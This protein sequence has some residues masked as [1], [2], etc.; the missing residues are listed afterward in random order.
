MRK[1]G[2]ILQA[3][4]TPPHY[5]EALLREMRDQLVLAE[6]TYS[7]EPCNGRG[8]ISRLLPAYVLTNDINP[9]MKADFH[10]DATRQQ[11]WRRMTRERGKPFWTITNPPFKH[12]I[13]ILRCALAYSHNVAML[14]RLSFLEPTKD[15]VEL[16]QD[17]PPDR[18][19][20]LPRYRFKG[21]GTDSVTCAWGIWDRSETGA[22]RVAERP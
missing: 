12:I 11:E 1:L 3:Y 13:P 19:I 18:L 6:G 22:I 8:A 4:D 21:T 9:R 5:V 7:F 17:H 2:G 20:V 16:L 15:R 10:F 14:F